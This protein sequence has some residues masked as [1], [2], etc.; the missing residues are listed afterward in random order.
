MQ[1]VAAWKGGAD[2][3]DE[4][5]AALVRSWAQ[6]WDAPAGELAQTTS[7][8][9]VGR[10]LGLGTAQEL[11]LKF[12][13]T[14]RIHAE[15]FSGAEVRHGPMALVDSGFPVII[16]SQPDESRPGLQALGEEF[17]SRGARV[18]ASGLDLPGAVALPDCGGAPMLA[19][20]LTIQGCYKLVEAVA[21]LRGLDPDAPP[22]LAKVTRTL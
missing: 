13:E 17:V 4:L 19:P 11:A 5:P 14:C 10:G 15:A 22:Y 1:L 18:F 16:L 9:V 3:L 21:R 6:D 8:Y 12:K 2:L 20:L 7:L